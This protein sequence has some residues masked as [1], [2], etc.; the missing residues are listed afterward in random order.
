MDENTCSQIE[1]SSITSTQRFGARSLYALFLGTLIIAL[2]GYSEDSHALPVGGQPV[3][4]KISI[5]Q[6]SP[7]SLDIKQS[8]RQGIIN[9]S[10]YNLSSKDKVQYIQPTS[11]SITLNRVVNGSPS[12]IFGL[13]TANGRVWIVNPAGI[14]FG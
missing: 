6:A 8:S 14:W 2:T 7:N 10:S 9:W 1:T 12:S 3:A 5:Q 11:S 13:I 4:G